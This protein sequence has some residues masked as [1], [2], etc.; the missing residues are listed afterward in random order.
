MEANSTPLATSPVLAS[1]DELQRALTY[2]QQRVDE[3]G[4]ANVQAD[5]IISAIKSDLRIKNDGF[6]LLAELQESIDAQMPIEELI[7]KTLEGINLRLQMDRSVFL[8][9]TP[10]GQGFGP[11]FGL[12]FDAAA[13]GRFPA[14][15]VAFEAT[16]TTPGSYLLVNKATPSTPLVEQLREQLGVPFFVALPVVVGREM[17]GV[18]LAGRYKEIKPFAPPVSQSGVNIMRAIAGF[19]AVSW[20]NA[21]QFI[22]LEQQVQQRTSELQSSLTE[23]RSTQAQ[24]IQKEKLASLGEL[25]AGIAHEI[26]NPLNFVNNFADLAAELVEELEAQRQQPA[27]DEALESELLADLKQSLR[28]VHAH[29]GRAASIVRGMLEHAR[30]STGPRQLTNLTD[31]AAEY[32]HLAYQ[33]LRAKDESFSAELQTDFAPQLAAVDAVGADIGRVLLNLFNNA[34]YAV[35]QRQRAGEPGY[36]PLVRVSTRQAGSYVEI[37]VQDNGTGMSEAVRTKVFQPFFSTKPPGEG[38]GLGLSLA[39]DIVVQGHGG[40]LS[41]A[42]QPAIGTTFTLSLPVPESKPA[43][44]AKPGF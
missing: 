22:L 2:Y 9:R 40:T 26:Q 28:K 12:G 7:N 34:F 16:L 17:A 30:Q 42:S 24:L 8:G 20:A 41:V 11:R 32:L 14:I 15:V 36:T 5:A 19:I 3:L 27:R 35:R 13:L 43:T 38:T 4:G 25:T 21:H 44:I 10:D 29:G 23:L 33:S 6:D 18:L 1:A 39:H 37:R 31:L